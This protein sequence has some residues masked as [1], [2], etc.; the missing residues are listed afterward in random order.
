M[1]VE[2][3]AACLIAG[4]NIVLTHGISDWRI[5]SPG[6]CRFPEAHD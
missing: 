4:T 5:T 6:M 3:D 2:I 1:S